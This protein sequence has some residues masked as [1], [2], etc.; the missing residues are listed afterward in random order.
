MKRALSILVLLA[1]AA[2]MAV[3]ADAPTNSPDRFDIDAKLKGQLALDKAKDGD[4]VTLE[5][6]KDVKVGDKVVIPKKATLTGKMF[7][8]PAGLSF[9]I[10]KAEWQGG[11]MPLN[12]YIA[13]TVAIAGSTQNGDSSS[14]GLGSFN[15][16]APEGNEVTE[17]ADPRKAS[18]QISTDTRYGGM[19]ADSGKLVGDPV[20]GQKILLPI[21][22]DAQHGSHISV[23]PKTRIPGNT[24]VI[25][26]HLDPEYP[27]ALLLNDNPKGRAAVQDARAG[28]EK[29]EAKDQFMLGSLYL[30]GAVLKPDLTKAAAWLLKAADQGLPEAQT[31]M[32]VLYVKGDGV[33]Q[34]PVASYM[35]FKLA[36]DAGQSQDQRA[37]TMLEG[38][39][40]PEQI[41]EA[42]KRADDWKQQHKK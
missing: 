2:S 41:A 16:N 39:L 7:V 6:A 22:P 4:S 9:L 29:G 8:Q 3:A 32:G 40:K 27:L 25:L 37:L 10:E 30:Q 28:A 42:K 34:D 33:P 5:V 20:S 31:D 19:N 23:N 1:V 15:P 26:R 35:W 24:P 21:A 18:S 11:S 36:T 17:Q 38:Q 12:A 13:Q 14:G